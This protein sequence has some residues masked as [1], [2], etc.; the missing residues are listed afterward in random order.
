MARATVLTN[1]LER[2]RTYQ[3]PE[4]QLN[5]WLIVMLAA[6]ATITGVFGYFLSVQ[7][8]FKV[9]SPWS[10]TLP[11]IHPPTYFFLKLIVSLSQ[12]AI[13]LLHRHRLPRHPL[14]PHNPRPNRPAPTPP[15]HR[16][17][18]L[19]HPLRPLPHRPDRNIHPTLRPHRIRK[20]LLQHLHAQ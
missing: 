15:R 5:F 14:H 13:P 4:A 6:S 18:R 11:K 19:L 12:Q 3:W 17:A 7:N 9:G 20:Q 1:V 2:K 10:V 16:N 8:Q